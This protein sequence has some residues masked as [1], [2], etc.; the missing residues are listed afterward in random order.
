M[1]ATQETF[2]EMTRGV[3]ALAE[4]ICGGRV[5][6][7]HEG[8]YS[9]VYAPFCGHAAIAALA[10][11]PGVDDPFGPAVQARQPAADVDAFLLQRIEAMAA[12]L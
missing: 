7:V 1:L 3:M 4:D 6:M 10:G 2:R 5:A 9:E 8:G 12:T 11:A